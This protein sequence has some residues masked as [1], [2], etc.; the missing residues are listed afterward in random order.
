[1]CQGGRGEG[2]GHTPSRFECLN[3][4]HSVWYACAPGGLPASSACL[5]RDQR[6][7][8]APWL[9]LSSVQMEGQSICWGAVG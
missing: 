2:G 5:R 7:E 1:M 9:R 4:V 3:T 6:L 8:A